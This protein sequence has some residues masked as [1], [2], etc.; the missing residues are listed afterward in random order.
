MF[1]YGFVTGGKKTSLEEALIVFVTYSS[2]LWSPLELLILHL[3]V[4]DSEYD[5]ESSWKGLRRVP[6]RIKVVS[7][8]AILRITPFFFFFFFY[9][10]I[11][12]PEHLWLSREGKG[13]RRHLIKVVHLLLVL[14]QQNKIKLE[15]RVSSFC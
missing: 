1:A 15:K 9:Q 5:C 11:I 14:L 6:F 12:F 4:L 13:L 8:P 3:Y 10:T 7:N 2:S